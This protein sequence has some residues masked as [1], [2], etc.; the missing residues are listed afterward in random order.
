MINQKTI[1]VIVGISI[2]AAF[3]IFL[4]NKSIGENPYHLK[5]A[6][7]II[8]MKDCLKCHDVTTKIKIRICTGD[9]CLYSKS[10]SLMHHYPPIGKE[11]D[12]ATLTDIEKAGCILEND[13]VTC[14]SCHDLTKPPPHLIQDGDKLCLICHKN[15]RSN[16]F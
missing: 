16:S 2:I 7:D 13:K 4:N 9:N 1:N 8:T 10:H 6:S 12:Y 14:L 3:I 5:D 11:K 15:L